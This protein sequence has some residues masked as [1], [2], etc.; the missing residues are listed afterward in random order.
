MSAHRLGSDPDQP[1]DYPDGRPLADQPQ[2]RQDFPTDVAEDDYVGRREVHQ[3]SGPEP[4]AL[5]RRSMLDRRG[6]SGPQTWSLSG[7]V[8]RPP[9]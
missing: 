9:G 3:V 8:H 7:A 6:E 1:R 2:W 5:R 4:V